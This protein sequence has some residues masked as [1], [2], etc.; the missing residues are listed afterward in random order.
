MKQLITILF[1]IF[2]QIIYAENVEI[3][4]FDSLWEIVYQKSFIRQS[5]EFEKESAKHSF[6][7]SQRHWL[8]R[9][10]ISGQWFSTNDPTQVFFS[11]LG[12]RSIV[13]TDFNPNDL[14]NPGRENFKTASL[15]L[16]LPLYEGGFKSS[17]TTMFETLVK[18]S[19]LEI[20]ARKSEEYS[21]LTRQYGAL[22]IYIKN[23]KYLTELKSSLENIISRYQVGSNS[24]PVGYSGLLGLKG[25]KNRIDGHL[26]ELDL[27]ISQSKNWI[28]T[29]TELNQNWTPNLSDNLND[30]V[31][32]KLSSSKVVSLSTM[33][34]AQEL[35][36][37]T[38]DQAK[39]M[40]KSRHLPRI[41]L[42]A[43]NNYFNGQRDT[44][45][46]QAYGIYFMW[47]LFNS[48]SYGRVYEANA[49]YFAG[50]AKLEAGK[51]EERMMLDRLNTTKITLVK[52]LLLI[53][54]SDILLREQ[55]I[56]AM[57]LF[58]SGMLSALQLAEV[59]N[60]RVDLIE[61]KNKIEADYLEVNSRIYQLN[62]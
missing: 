23:E 39:D 41:G 31:L 13:Q 6:N 30:F 21:E 58:R 33:L 43:Q 7:R 28:N 49:K 57:K 11:N 54:D 1:F 52:S 22:L 2:S 5:S 26:Y 18:A 15:G 32:K 45:N 55:S 10:F 37:S 34:M 8:P 27:K 46:A 36:V 40:E 25:V 38:L 17:Q 60:R 24:N 16:D 44:A 50:K 35:K 4:N 29:K 3:K 19:E 9:A 51:Q 12:Q 61:Q 47:D 62:N 14:N 53:E 42:F 56:N 20:K 48:D 59:V